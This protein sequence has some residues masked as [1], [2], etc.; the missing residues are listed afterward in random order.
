MLGNISPAI[1]HIAEEESKSESKVKL[2]SF[3]Q[4]TGMVKMISHSFC[5]N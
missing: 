1:L 5:L 4:A 3:Y 2:K